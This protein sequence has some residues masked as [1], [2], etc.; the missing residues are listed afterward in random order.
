M[1]TCRKIPS[2]PSFIFDATELALML[3][4]ADALI[5]RSGFISGPFGPLC[6]VSMVT[7]Y[8]LWNFTVVVEENL[9]SEGGKKGLKPLEWRSVSDSPSSRRLSATLLFSPS[10]PLM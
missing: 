3:Q 5:L 9:N 1:E 2:I 7:H 6:A 8:H 10:L 4:L